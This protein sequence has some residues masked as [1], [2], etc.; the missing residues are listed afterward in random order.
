[1]NKLTT[2][3]LG[4]IAFSFSSGALADS[5]QWTKLSQKIVAKENFNDGYNLFFISRIVPEDKTKPHQA[6]YLVVRY[7]D[8]ATDGSIAP[9]QVESVSE[10]WTID[11]KGNW[12]VDQWQHVADK[13]GKLLRVTHMHLVEQMD[14][15]VLVY[16]SLPT[17]DVNSPEETARWNTYLNSWYVSQKIK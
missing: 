16:D 5:A 4:L 14:S 15:A 7:L 2:L 9:S 6:D 3:A 1:M 17:G 11:A 13:N 12:D 10:K 8:T